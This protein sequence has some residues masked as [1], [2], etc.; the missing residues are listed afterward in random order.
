MN[1]VGYDYA[2]PG[3]H[4]FDYGMEVFL[5]I[6][7]NKA[8]YEY[9]SANFTDLRTLL[10][11]L[12]PFGIKDVNGLKIAFVGITTP[13]SVTKST[14]EY[15]KDENGSFIYG[16]PTFDM[17]DGVLY[18]SVQDSVDEAIEQG[19][20][21]VIAVGHLGIL[22][23]S[24]NWKSTDIIANTNGIDAFID[25]HSHEKIEGDTYKNKDNEEV[26]LSSTQTKFEYFGKLTISENGIKTEL[27]ET[28]EVDVASMSDEAKNEYDRVKNIVDGY[29]EQIAYLYDPVGVSEVKLIAYDET[30][31][32]LVRK[33]ETN[34]GDFVADAYRYVTG[35]DVAICNGGGVRSEI[36]A[37]SVAR[38]DVMNVNPWN[39]EMCVIEATGQQIADVL[40]HG[41]C[42]YPQLSGGFFQVSG[43]TFEVDAWKESPVIKDAWGNFVKIND[44]LD[45]RVRN[46]KIGGVPIDLEKPIH[47]QEAPMCS[48]RA[49]TV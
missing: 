41:V 14:P 39:N 17:Q 42:E 23:I 28:A 13:E 47:W 26:I 1:A 40:E 11:V 33:S 2:V 16:F 27:I 30:G 19:A 43:V 24:E 15:F 8:E 4:E 5:D 20:D 29:N 48:L 12:E 25:A 7:E 37:G 34:M 10:P 32:W 31:N 45:R 22:G 3:N 18:Q 44:T 49:E 38:I 21:V 9:I 35:A 46:I 36:E 6:A